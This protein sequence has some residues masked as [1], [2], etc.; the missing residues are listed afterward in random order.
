MR[1]GRNN[2]WGVRI[3]TS[4]PHDEFLHYWEISKREFNSAEYVTLKKAPIQSPTYHIAG[5]MLNSSDGQLTDA[6]ALELS[7]EMGCKIGIAHRTAPLDKR[8]SDA[9]WTHAKRV[10]KDKHGNVD[11]QKLFRHAP[12]AQG[13]YTA[14]RRDAVMTAGRLHEK[15]GRHRT[16]GQYPRQPDG[17]RM[18]FVPASYYLDMAGQ[19]K[20]GEIFKQQIYFQNNVTLAPIPV[21]DPNQRF[22]KHQNR[23]MQELILDLVCK[24]KKNEPYFRHLKKKYHRNFKTKEYMVSI[25][26]EIYTQAAQ[27]LRTLK[28]T[29]TETY[30]P[31]VGD[32]LKDHTEQE[33]DLQSTY[34]G[35][36]SFSG[37]SLDA[38]DRYLN[39]DGQF[40]ILGM[41]RIGQ[42]LSQVR[43][44]GE[45]TR[46]FQ[47]TSTATGYTGHTGQTIPDIPRDGESTTRSSGRTPMP[48][49]GPTSM[50]TDDSDLTSPQWQLF[51][52][53]EEEDKLKQKIHDAQKQQA[54]QRRSNI[55]DTERERDKT[56]ND[57]TETSAQNDNNICN[58]T[59]KK[60]DK[61]HETDQ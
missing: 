30:S 31:E 52:S 32:A 57:E 56:D 39:G 13:V 24:E 7:K 25:H 37:I 51:G 8:T 4:I 1:G 36:A 58:P 46:S 14:T 9:L 50:V 49:I 11:R 22:E 61:D 59:D 17:T 16:D 28:K 10:A 20:A 47:V 60:G 55:Q 5:Y 12:F 19:S 41:E 43:G 45:D 35:T 38:S 53:K 3:T 29:L 27:V 40:I 2:G 33:P 23:T 15:Y 26:N 18:R 44:H 54:E 48:S 42:N 34:G 21:R 6:L